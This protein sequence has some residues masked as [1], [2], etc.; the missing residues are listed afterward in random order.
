MSEAPCPYDATKEISA[1]RRSGATGRHYWKLRHPES[2][3]IIPSSGTLHL[4]DNRGSCP[5]HVWHSARS[6][7]TLN[8]FDFNEN[9]KMKWLEVP[10]YESIRQ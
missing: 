8:Y 2:A 3:K 4:L 9:F 10:P 1:A 6:Y 7:L 5:A